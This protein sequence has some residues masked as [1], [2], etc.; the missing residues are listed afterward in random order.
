MRKLL[1]IVLLSAVP[2]IGHCFIDLLDI[3]LVNAQKTSLGL[4]IEFSNGRQ[5][6][7]HLEAGKSLL[8]RRGF[9]E[10]ITKVI[11][12]Q[13]KDS[14]RVYDLAELRARTAEKRRHG[15]WLYISGVRTRLISSDEK[16]AL[17]RR[18]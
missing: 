4:I 16:H 17:E 9:G 15:E 5:I 13:P 11:V 8:M 12:R 7:V 14:A 1:L 3:G 6:D 18:P 2:S 10:H